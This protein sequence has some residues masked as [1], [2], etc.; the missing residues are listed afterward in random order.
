MKLKFDITG[1]TCAACSARVEKVT[2]QIPGV[3]N[4]EVNL[5]SGTMT[6][7]AND[8]TVCPQIESA[9]CNAGYGARRSGNKKTPD[10]QKNDDLKP[11]KSAAVMVTQSYSISG[12]RKP[13]IALTHQHTFA[14]NIAFSNSGHDILDT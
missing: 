1:M 12:K 2:K 4:V 6:L 11:V 5:L 10:A 3:E 9:V 14:V 13:H 7:D 8:E